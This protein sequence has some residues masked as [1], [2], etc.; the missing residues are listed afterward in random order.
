MPYTPTVYVNNTTPA[1]NA[2][3]LNKSETG[4]Q[5]AQAAAE[6]VP[7]NMGRVWLDDFAGADDDAKLTAALTA[8]AA[9]T[10]PRAVQLENRQYTFAT[11]NRVP[12]EGMRIL[13]P[14]GHSNP[15]RNSQ[16][17][18]ACRVHLTGTGGW[19]RIPTGQT[20]FGITLGRL[21][22]TGGSNA[23]IMTCEDTSA[24]VD[25]LIMYDI[26]AFQLKTILG[27]QT[28]KFL[29]TASMFYGDWEINNTYNGAFHLGGSDC[30]LWTDGILIDTVPAYISAGSSSGQYLLW[31][32]GLDKTDFGPVY[33]TARGD[34]SV[35]Y[36]GILVSGPTTDN[37]TASNQAVVNFLGG[38]VEGHFTDRARGC[39]VRVE[40]GQASFH[41]TRFRYGMVDPTVTGHTPQD[42]GV[43]HQ[44][45]GVLD[46]EG[47]YYDRAT[48]VA[49][50]VKFVHWAGTGASICKRT[51]K[52]ARGGTW[53]GLP[54]V[55]TA[56]D[57][58]AYVTGV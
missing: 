45:A 9:D 53:T 42:V 16:T 23:S 12:F 4:I 39:L 49:E 46:L 28:T 14:V 51:K 31:C 55:S 54:R 58:D 43:I 10:Y 7:T 18:M 33:I 3:N 5:T 8:V 21:S 38:D 20:I 47:C 52:G 2:T 15:E 29:M 25:Q 48:S 19:F 26:S 50:T 11:V 41:G 13:G 35:S 17:K 37:T 40:G 36:C 30:R 22:F 34:A 1:L 57:K 44:E 56:I 27:T 24:S 6:A 32:D